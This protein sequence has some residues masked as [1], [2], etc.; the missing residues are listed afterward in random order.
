MCVQEEDRLKAQNGG[1]VNYVNH[2]KK[3]MQKKSF[4][5]KNYP[6]K[7]QWESGPSNA[8]SK[9][10]GK[11]PAQ[12]DQS[13]KALVQKEVAPNQCLWCK[14]MG[15]CPKECP[16]WMKHMWSKG[17]NI[18]TFVDETLYLSYDKSTWWIDSGATTQVSNSIQGMHPWRIL[19][20]GER[21]IKV[22]NRVKAEV[23]AIGELP[24]KLKDGFTLL[25]HDVL[26][27]PSLS[28]NLIPVSC[29]ADNGFECLFRTEQCVILFNE[30]CVG[31][32]FRQDK[33]LM[34]AMHDNMTECIGNVECM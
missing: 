11:G 18:I 22:A 29:L 14:K 28:R 6:P 13:H 19:T 15:H 12:D 8:P 20:K 26:Y 34:L 25:L 32:A 24:V 7:N 21:R 5:S 9:P 16:K 27:V 10:H 4:P 3:P 17:E 33:L 2:S 31:L 30:V 1:S 23:E